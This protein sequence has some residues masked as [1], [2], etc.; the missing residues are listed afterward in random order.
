MT[1]DFNNLIDRKNTNCIKYDFARERG[2]KEDLIPLWVADMDFITP[3]QVIDTL[4]N[5]SKHGIFGYSEVKEDYFLVLKKWFA[6]H[7]NWDIAPTWLVKTPGVVFAISMAVRAFTK[8]GDGVIIQ[9]PV[10]Y[11]FSESINSNN[12]KLINSPLVYED[13]EY[14]INFEDFE[15][16]IIENKV[17]LFILCNPHNPVGRVWAR[18]ELIKLGD[19]CVKHQVK[20]VSD[21]IHADFIHPGFKHLVFANLKPEFADITVTCTAPSKTFNLAGLQVSNNI[22]INHALKSA[23]K[24]EILR[25]G[26][27]QLNTMGLYACK[28]AYEFGEEWLEGLKDYLHQNLEYVSAF[29]EKELPMLHLVKPQGTY[30]LWIDF[31]SLNLSEE[32]LE[33]FI[34]DQAKLWLDGGTM[35]GPEGLGFQRIN[36][37][38]PRLVLEKA[39]TQLKDAVLAL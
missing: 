13:G 12:R 18:E 28:A 27:S 5:V 24:K 34:T 36:M 21:E 33:A 30:L 9:R 17:K 23:F 31:R 14:H 32:D 6:K 26:Y 7:Y 11:P 29:L 39:L 19:I 15:Q 16:K 1:H 35:F 20:V 10:Y 22:I 4:V 25:S 38:C 3:P 37:A 8:E 2:K